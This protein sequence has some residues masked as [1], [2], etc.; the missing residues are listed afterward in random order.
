MNKFGKIIF[1]LSVLSSLAW[2]YL[3]GYLGDS[4]QVAESTISFKSK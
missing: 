3:G 1:S 2:G 4:H